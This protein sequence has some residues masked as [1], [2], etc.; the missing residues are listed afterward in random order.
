MKP[1]YLESSLVHRDRWMIS[2]VDVLTIL[3]VFF[4]AAAA[5]TFGARA[6]PKTAPTGSSSVVAAG[7]PIIT[8]PQA[9][10]P[11]ALTPS[12]SAV[13]AAPPL[14]N[15]AELPR[16]A[17]A[18][19]LEKLKAQGVAARLEPR[20]LVI[21]LPQ[22]VLYS[23]G[24]DQ[25]S[26]TAIPV[27]EQVVEILRTLPNKIS[28]IGHADATPIHNRRFKNNWELSAARGLRLLELLSTNY[29][30]EE[31][32]LSVSSDGANQP[33]SPNDTPEGRATNRRVE[34]LVLN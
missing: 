3:L 34:I 29:G 33:A 7:A 32:R 4:I 26:R 18:D 5:K 25:V 17:L 19:A 27:V 9:I 12:S 31:S 1:K 6:D 8:A 23:P 10:T 13:S 15:M 2:Y 28:L 22:T 11:A 16:S 30:I 14:P 21:S 24:E 20:G